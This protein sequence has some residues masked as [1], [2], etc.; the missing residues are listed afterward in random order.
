MLTSPFI[1]AEDFVAAL[2]DGRVTGEYWLVD[3][4]WNELLDLIVHDRE[5]ARVISD[6]AVILCMNAKC[7]NE[8]KDIV[9]LAERRLRE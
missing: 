2:K 8:M 9:A 3:D 5:A 1:S 6:S 7:A 4:V